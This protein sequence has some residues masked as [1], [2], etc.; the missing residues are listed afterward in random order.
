MA[1]SSRGLGH[2]PFTEATGVRIPL[3]LLKNWM[4]FHPVRSKTLLSRGVFLCSSLNELRPH[5]DG[6]QVG[7]H[8]LLLERVQPPRGSQGNI[9]SSPARSDTKTVVPDIDHFLAAGDERSLHPALV[10]LELRFGN[11]HRSR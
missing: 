9:R 10:L 1:P 5:A 8:P 4:K 6:T 11:E 3:G 2:L 7:S